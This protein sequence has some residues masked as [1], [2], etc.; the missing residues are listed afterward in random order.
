MVVTTAKWVTSAMLVVVGVIHLLP[1]TGVTG[2]PRLAALYGI[3]IADP[4]LEILL[5]HRAVLF[6]LL[7]AFL[8]LAAWRP[9]LQPLALAAGWLSVVSFLWLAHAA[10]DYNGHLAR[11][12]AADVLALVCLAAGSLS[13]L[14]RFR[15]WP[16]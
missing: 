14:I 15:N 5:R 3:E 9:S 10:G 13:Y 6:G 8:L 4:N 11:V 1:V 12:V 16:T 7:G 2:G